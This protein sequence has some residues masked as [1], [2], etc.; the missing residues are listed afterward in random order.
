MNMTTPHARGST[1][2][3]FEANTAGLQHRMRDLEIDAALLSKRAAVDMPVI[4]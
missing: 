2:V 4:T 3:E 1:Q